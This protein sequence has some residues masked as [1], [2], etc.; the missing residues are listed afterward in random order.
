MSES[1][2][3][4][5]AATAAEMKE[6]DTIRAINETEAALIKS[7]LTNYFKVK[8]IPAVINIQD[9]GT[10]EIL[11]RDASQISV[12]DHDTITDTVKHFSKTLPAHE[13]ATVYVE[14][15]KDF[16]HSVIKFELRK[17]E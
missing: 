11:F 2:W 8:G 7:S 12:E 1:P 9:T 15:P 14:T 6:F 17:Y 13:Y 4:P 5:N 3:T 16:S 10:I